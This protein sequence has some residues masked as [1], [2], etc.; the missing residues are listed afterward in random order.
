LSSV[1][2]IAG[3]DE[4]AASGGAFVTTSYGSDRRH[5]TVNATRMPIA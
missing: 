2:H 3:Y 4:R 5:S 1:A